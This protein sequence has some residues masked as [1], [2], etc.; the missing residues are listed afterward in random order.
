MFF[1]L[2]ASRTQPLLGASVCRDDSL[3]P[4]FPNVSAYRDDPWEYPVYVVK[5]LNVIQS[6]Y[7]TYMYTTLILDE[8]YH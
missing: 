2:G 4:G 6:I 3:A 7:S 1:V 8:I 5:D